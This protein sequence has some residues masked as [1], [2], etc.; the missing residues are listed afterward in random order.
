M[1]EEDFMIRG[2]AWHLAD[3]KSLLDDMLEPINYR[4]YSMTDRMSMSIN[5]VH[6]HR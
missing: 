5:Q 4:F 1:D 6:K 2:M 3:Y